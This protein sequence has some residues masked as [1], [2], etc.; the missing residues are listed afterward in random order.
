MSTKLSEHPPAVRVFSGTMTAIDRDWL[1]MLHK[2][3]KDVDYETLRRAGVE[4]EAL[5]EFLGVLA[6]DDR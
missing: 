6:L 1:R 2:V 4:D 3:F 5:R